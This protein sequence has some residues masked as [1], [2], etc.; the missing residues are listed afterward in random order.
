MTE[1]PKQN[2]TL[3]VSEKLSDISNVSII[4]NGFQNIAKKYLSTQKA[5]PKG[6]KELALK[7]LQ[8]LKDSVNRYKEMPNGEKLMVE[9]AENGMGSTPQALILS[10]T[11]TNIRDVRILLEGTDTK[12]ILNIIDEHNIGTGPNLPFVLQFLPKEYTK[13]GRLTEETIKKAQIEGVSYQMNEFLNDKEGKYIPSFDGDAFE[14]YPDII[15]KALSRPGTILN[16][17][18]NMIG[19]S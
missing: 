17:Y 15:E 5:N 7:Q 13:D 11:E 18:E 14:K 8:E 9:Y 1:K 16:A 4:S 3:E 12:A 2:A 10:Q 6:A 19:F